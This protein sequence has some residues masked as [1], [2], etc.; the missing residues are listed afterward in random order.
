MY[1]FCKISHIDMYMQETKSHSCTMHSVVI[2]LSNSTLTLPLAP[3]TYIY[4]HT[5]TF[6]CGQFIRINQYFGPPDFPHPIG[7]TVSLST[8]V[9]CTWRCL[10]TIGTKL[11][12][13]LLYFDLPESEGCSQNSLQIY[14]GLFERNTKVANLCGSPAKHVY[15]VSGA[16]MT[17][18]LETTTPGT[19]R[20]FHAVCEV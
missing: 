15:Q 17:V 5:G 18:V 1:C 8:N 6:S 3:S 11:K 20:G 9:K 19:F 2:N 14:D 16:Y 4:T 12:L 13:R 10:A 7:H